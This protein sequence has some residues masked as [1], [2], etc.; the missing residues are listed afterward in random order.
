MVLLPLAP[1]ASV[2]ANST[3]LAYKEHYLYHTIKILASFLK[4]P[5]VEHVFAFAEFFGEFFKFRS[6]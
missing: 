1:Q 6:Y 2:S 3:T 4:I 5:S